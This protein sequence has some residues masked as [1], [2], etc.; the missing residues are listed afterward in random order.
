[1]SSTHPSTDR[2]RLTVAVVG[3]TGAVGREMLHLL[4]TRGFGAGTVRALAS[5][6]SAGS[7]LEFE[8][9]TL[10]V[11]ELTA[12]SFGGVDIALFSAGGG[13]SL[14]FAPRAAA[15]GAL[16]VDNSSAFRYE[17]DVPLVVPEVNLEASRQALA[18]GGRRIIANPNC[19][20]IQ[21]VVALQ[22][23]H[24]A[25]GIRRV[26]VSTYQSVSGAGQKG[27]DELLA[28]TRAHL[29]G[30][31]EPAPAKFAH[32]IAF[33]ALPHIDS[34]LDNGYTREEM[35]MVWET[36]KIMSL[37]SLPVSATC[38]RIPVLRSHS[39]AVTV[40]LDRPL[41]AQ[42]ARAVLA[43]APGITVVDDPATASY[44]LPRAAESQGTTYVGRI[45]VDP[46]FPNVLHLWVVSDNLWKGAA[47][48]AVE[49]A[50]AVT[51]QGWL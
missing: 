28:G 39:E 33:N 36:R 24:T 48:N 51:D 13:T 27:I 30:E 37:P 18:E 46:D 45:R 32:P 14:E 41:S 22:P 25:A 15:A 5:R 10:T 6:R 26:I 42:E 16:V 21:M 8:G 34:F 47:L 29:A 2:S 17:A 50:E 20:T 12:D 7:T 19:S 23:L 1:M 49:I 3:A 40:E 11:E 35:K 31:P 9:R 38:V 44:P 4:A 43:V